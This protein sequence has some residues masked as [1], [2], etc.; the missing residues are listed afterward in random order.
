[1][2]SKEEKTPV[3]KLGITG[4]IFAGLMRIVPHPPNMT[5]MGGMA[6]YSGARMS[7]WKAAFIP[8][9]L[10][11][12]T[13]LA[14]SA[15]HGYP[16]FSANMI[17]VIFSI[18][19]YFLIGRFLRDTENPGKVLT[20]ILLGS[21]QFFIITNLGVWALYN[22]YPHSVEGLIACFVAAIPFFT[23]TIVGDVA[24]TATLF[25]AHHY[26]AKRFFPREAI[27]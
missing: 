10:M 15:I 1:M 23:N 16:F 18:M 5:P 22:Y 25:V 9:V 12:V 14:L 2:N 3:E 17:V 11:V 19:V 26:L 6:I 8:L 7:G 27:A 24:Y 21:V 20:G 4:T 13:N